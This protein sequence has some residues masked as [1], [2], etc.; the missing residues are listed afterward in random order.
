MRNDIININD[1]DL[2]NIL[3]DEKSYENILIYDVAY[4]T[5]YSAKPLRIIFDKADGCI[6][7]YGETKYLALFHSSENYERIF[8]RVRYLIMLIKHINIYSKIITC[9]LLPQKRHQHLIPMMKIQLP[10]EKQQ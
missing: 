2:N 9:K 1:L 3:R 6:R 8:D 10:L 4:K 5:S 7:K